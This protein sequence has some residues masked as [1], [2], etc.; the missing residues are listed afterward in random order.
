MEIQ[1]NTKIDNKDN[2]I[3]SN[4]FKLIILFFVI[5]LSYKVMIEFKKSYNFKINE[6]YKI[7]IKNPDILNNIKIAI[8]ESVDCRFIKLTDSCDLIDKQL[9]VMNLYEIK[10]GN[11]VELYSKNQ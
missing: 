3:Y 2:Y 4:I 8:N 7:A 5:C 6:E 11:L 9:K 1:V 10:S